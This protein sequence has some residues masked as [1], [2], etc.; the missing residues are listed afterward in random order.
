VPLMRDSAVSTPEQGAG[1]RSH[2]V[3]FDKSMIREGE[4]RWGVQD[5]ARYF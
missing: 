3:M 1:R 5:H 4:A 2:G